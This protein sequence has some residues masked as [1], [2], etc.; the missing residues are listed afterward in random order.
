MPDPELVEAL[1]R[2]VF[3]DDEP[4]SGA[5]SDE[6]PAAGSRVS[7]CGVSSWVAPWADSVGGL[8]DGLALVE[9]LRLHADVMA[10]SRGLGGPSTVMLMRDAADEIEA[11]RR[12]CQP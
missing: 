10:A 3:G 7:S 9:A 2:Q 8:R 5:R 4:D 12:Q 6:A 11:L 1:A